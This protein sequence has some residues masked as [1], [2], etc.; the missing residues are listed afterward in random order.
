[1]VTNGE[2]KTELSSRLN[3]GESEERLRSSS[4][5]AKDI[6]LYKAPNKMQMWRVSVQKERNKECRGESGVESS[7]PSRAR[8]PTYAGYHVR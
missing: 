3:R 8:E 4:T 2:P 5:I 7:K 1:M 6:G